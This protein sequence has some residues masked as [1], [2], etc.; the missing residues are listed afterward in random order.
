MQTQ[1]AV[2]FLCFYVIYC[3]LRVFCI[4]FS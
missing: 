1:Y 4:F 2:M 3:F